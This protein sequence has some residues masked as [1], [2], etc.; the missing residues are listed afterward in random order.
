MGLERFRELGDCEMGSYS[1]WVWLENSGVRLRNCGNWDGA[2]SCEIGPWSAS[3]R[4]YGV[5][6]DEYWVWGAVK[7]AM[8]VKFQICLPV[9]TYSVLHVVWLWVSVWWPVQRSNQGL[10]VGIGRQESRLR[11]DYKR[12]ARFVTVLWIVKWDPGA[13]GWAGEL[14]GCGVVLKNYGVE[15]SGVM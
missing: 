6:C 9:P 8:G 11:C 14:R 7:T 10:L 2:G 4:P 1:C 13:V 12:T 15:L 5:E 3:C